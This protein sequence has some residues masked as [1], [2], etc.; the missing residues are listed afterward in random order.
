MF[1]FFGGAKSTDYPELQSPKTTAE[2]Q[3]LIGEKRK[4]ALE[5]IESVDGWTDVD[6]SSF[7]PNHGVIV[8]SKQVG[9]QTFECVRVSK[10]VQASPQKVFD[11]VR[12][13]VLA[14]RQVWDKDLVE[15]KVLQKVDEDTNVFYSLNNAP[16]PVAKRDLV[17][18]TRA[19]P[20]ADGKFL[21]VSTSVNYDHQ[22]T[23]T[24]AVRAVLTLASWLIAP[25]DGQ[26]SQSFVTRLV[27]LDP[28]GMIPA[29]VVNAQKAKAGLT[30]IE[31][32]KLLQ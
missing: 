26:P 28:K 22:A 20:E 3:S 27:Q 16:F 14:E 17:I 24:S 23:D 25:I 29:F 18:V 30:L 6:T 32:E 10:L 15:F 19:A 9:D 2:F 8:Q 21:L 31:V 1:G 12:T 4:A 13:T 7:P 5:M 11:F